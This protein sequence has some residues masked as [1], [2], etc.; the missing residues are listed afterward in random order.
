MF[1]RFCG[2][3]IPADSAFCNVCGK[4]QAANPQT[5]SNSAPFPA[6]SRANPAPPLSART[7]P[8]TVPFQQ[9]V[10]RPPANKTARASVPWW[11]WALGVVG[12]LCCAFGLFRN[13]QPAPSP[14]HQTVYQDA[15][16]GDARTS[17]FTVGDNWTIT[18]ACDLSS[19][20]GINYNVIIEVV[21]ASTGVRDSMAVNE[22]CENGLTSGT[23]S[24]IAQGGTYQLQITSEGVWSVIVQD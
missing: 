11:G 13:Y 7:A 16:S 15:G 4:P 10:T 23:S 5:Y 1:C 21:D 9:N 12:I 6:D 24:A 19:S 8:P 17:Q 2:A 3:N 14:T 20:G 18:W 22:L